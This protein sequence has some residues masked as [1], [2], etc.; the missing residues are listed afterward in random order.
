[1]SGV[2]RVS[3]TRVNGLESRL[4]AGFTLIELIVVIALVSVLAVTALDRLFYYQERAEKAVMDATLAAV[5]MGLRIRL[6]ELTVTNKQNVAAELERENPM[7]WL[8]EPPANYAGEY[9]APGARG[10]WYFATQARQLVYVPNNTSY[11]RWEQPEG[12]REL[13]FQVKLRYDEMETAGGKS[14]SP[15]GIAIIASRPYRWF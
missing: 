5:K 2:N 6:A 11:L 4:A 3:A 12:E 10:T 13:R 14:K 15:A 7:R 8:D 9:R 1:M